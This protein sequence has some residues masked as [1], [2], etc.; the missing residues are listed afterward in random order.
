MPELICDDIVASFNVVGTLGRGGQKLVYAVEHPQYGRC[1]LKIGL[2]NNPLGLE[3]IVR[4]VQTLRCISS[5]YYPRQFAFQV[6]DGQRFYILEER[7]EG[8]PL[9]QRLTEF[10]STPAATRLVLG[11]VDA[12]ILLWERRIV[13]RDVKPDNI[14]ITPGDRPKVID[15]GIARL[16]D[17]ASLTH[18]L[19]PLGPCT[20]NHAS[21]EQLQNR[22]HEINHRADQFCVG[23]IYGQLLLKG[24][25]PFDPQL[26][27]QGQSIVENILNGRWAESSFRSSHRIPVHAVLSKMLAREPHARYRT[28]QILR[29]ALNE[30]V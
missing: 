2:Y 6:V 15:L 18:S 17:L 22:K 26:V 14:I 19:A 27:G 1:V 4:E 28:P 12:L 10:S 7:L 20:P 23:I 16:L 11:I 21:P 9:S 5:P 24:S 13:H 8:V 25:H 30:L 29:T 3:R